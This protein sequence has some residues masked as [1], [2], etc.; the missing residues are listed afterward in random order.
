MEHAKYCSERWRWLMV[1]LTNG[2]ARRAYTVVR[3]SVCYVAVLQRSRL[4]WHV[5]VLHVSVTMQRSSVAWQRGSVAWQRGSVEQQ[6]GSVA[7]QCYKTA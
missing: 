4:T 1:G 3:G 7:C 6:R 5:A 2:Q